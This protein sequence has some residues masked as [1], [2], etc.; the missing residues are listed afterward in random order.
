MKGTFK[1]SYSKSNGRNVF[2][3]Y[4]NGT[5][6]EISVYKKSVG[7]YYR[8]ENSKPLFY[9]LFYYGKNVVIKK[10]KIKGNYFV[11]NN[12]LDQMKKLIE[13]FGGNL[14]Q[15][16]YEKTQDNN[17]LLTEKNEQFI[18]MIKNHYESSNEYEGKKT[19]ENYRGSYA[20]DIEGYSDQDIDN[21]FEGDPD[22]YWNVD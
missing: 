21:I 17:W 18:K 14:F 4:L 16:L 3:Y 19:Y 5:D 1:E 9:T 11:Q 2:V 8:E 6:S 10:A 20:Q 13:Q 7:K 12:D 22:M 15:A